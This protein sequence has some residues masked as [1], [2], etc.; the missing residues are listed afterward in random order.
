MPVLAWSEE[1]LELFSDYSD[2]TLSKFWILH[3]PI[4]VFPLLSLV[5][6]SWGISSIAHLLSGDVKLPAVALEMLG[7]LI[8]Y[9]W[10]F[11][12]PLMWLNPLPALV[13]FTLS[14]GLGSILLALVFILNH[15]GR[16]VLNNEAAQ[17]KDFYELQ[18]LT[19]RNLHSGLLTDWI[20]GGLN[21]Q[22]EHHL[23]PSLP[24]HNYHLVAP[25]VQEAC[26]RHQ[27]PYHKVTF[28]QGMREVLERLRR[29]SELAEKSVSVTKA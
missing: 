11:G 6:L 15:N 25:L 9:A 3:Q 1:A 23:F 7:I 24:R 18:I 5:R 21:Y 19:S 28:L 26:A 16:S 22:V 8:H 27:I 10:Q 13:Y 29:V 2:D 14:Q 4:L 12:L 17:T 20:M